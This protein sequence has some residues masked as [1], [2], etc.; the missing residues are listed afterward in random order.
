MTCRF[1]H[2]LDSAGLLFP[3]LLLWKPRP[4]QKFMPWNMVS[5]SLKNHITPCPKL[6]FLEKLLYIPQVTVKLNVTYL[7]KQFWSPVWSVLVLIVPIFSYGIYCSM[8]VDV[9]SSL[10]YYCCSC[11]EES[12]F[13]LF[14]N[15]AS[16]M[17]HLYDFR[18]R[19][20]GNNQHKIHFLW[21]FCWSA[22]TWET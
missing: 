3:F 7:V 19:T 4:F 9:A 6:L 16:L 14:Y 8:V 5:L 10:G 1:L 2:N 18:I 17:I 12:W 21:L 15:F 22:T 20:E 13:I 11:Y